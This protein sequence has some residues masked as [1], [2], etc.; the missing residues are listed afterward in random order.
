MRAACLLV[1]AVSAARADEYA[2]WLACDKLCH[3]TH[4]PTPTPTAHPTPSPTLCPT[5]SP[6][7]CPTTKPTQSPTLPTPAP[8]V[9]EVVRNDAAGTS[10]NAS[11]ATASPTPQPTLQPTPLPSP[12]PT[13]NPT[14][15]PTL[16]PT[17]V[18]CTDNSQ[19]CSFWR[20]RGYCEL[21]ATGYYAS[22]DSQPG[23]DVG[24]VRALCEITCQVDSCMRTAAPTATPT[25]RPTP[26]PSPAPTLSPSPAPTAHP[27]P[28]PTP[29]PTRTPTPVHTAKPTPSPT[30]A[31]TL[32]PTFNASEPW[33]AT[34]LRPDSPTPSPAERHGCRCDLTARHSANATRLGDDG[35][36]MHTVAVWSFCGV[37]LLV[38]LWGVGNWVRQSFAGTSLL[39]AATDEPDNDDDHRGRNMMVLPVRLKTTRVILSDVVPLHE[40]DHRLNDRGMFITEL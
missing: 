18:P 7:A 16:S 24:M 27:T 8:T 17:F 28:A 26:S 37:W 19:L 29:A 23:V 20:D 6:T 33:N 13:V 31:P 12:A 1:V 32:S 34:N 22:W 11:N 15:S 25:E 36:P 40:H 3:P 39:F 4:M 30:I 38:L 10:T 35:I 5:P 2:D 14:P 21:H 9:Q